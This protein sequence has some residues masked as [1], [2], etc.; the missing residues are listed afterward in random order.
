MAFLNK[1]L[2]PP[3]QTDF[4]PCIRIG[5]PVA[6]AFYKIVK[7]PGTE[8]EWDVL[9]WVDRKGMRRGGNPYVLGWGIPFVENKIQIKIN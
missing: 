4:H 6:C 3:L 1:F 7:E 9:G 5:G 2:N 8:S